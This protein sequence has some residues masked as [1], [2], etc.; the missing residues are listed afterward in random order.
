MSG[1]TVKRFLDAVQGLF[2]EI[3][4]RH[5]SAVEGTGAKSQ[6]LNPFNH[7]KKILD[8]YG[9]TRNDQEL[10]G[11]FQTFL[12][13]LVAEDKDL[14]FGNVRW[15][16]QSRGLAMES[17][18]R[19][20]N[21]D[22]VK[23]C[24]EDVKEVA[25]LI[26]E[27]KKYHFALGNRAKKTK[28]PTPSSAVSEVLDDSD[29]GQEF[30]VESREV[31]RVHPSVLEGGVDDEKFIDLKTLDRKAKSGAPRRR[32]KL[33]EVSETLEENVDV[34]NGDLDV[35]KEIEELKILVKSLVA[36]RKKTRVYKKF[37]VNIDTAIVTHE[38][39]HSL[40]RRL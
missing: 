9:Y 27:R 10:S 26:E 18:G 37:V 34:E 3:K 25:K 21:L 33:S 8:A 38:S 40:L 30:F 31:S 24:F 32:N 4:S 12:D 19:I 5:V 28:S 35:R 16:D 15:G 22:V 20:L 23:G 39:L 11:F 14:L 1:L 17:F 6:P 7:A 29:L 36:T 13:N 2:Q